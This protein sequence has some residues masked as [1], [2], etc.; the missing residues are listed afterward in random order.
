M[1]QALANRPYEVA[2]AKKHQRRLQPHRPL[3]GFKATKIEPPLR[4]DL[5]LLRL[6]PER[7][8]DI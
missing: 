6:L 5:G 4:F 3:R 1:D 2:G 8:V 7:L